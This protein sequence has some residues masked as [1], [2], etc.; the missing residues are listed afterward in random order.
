MQKSEQNKKKKWD[1]FRRRKKSNFHVSWLNKE[2]K[3]KKFGN[4]DYLQM[5]DGEILMDDEDG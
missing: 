4:R 5:E 3:K 1:F 2:S